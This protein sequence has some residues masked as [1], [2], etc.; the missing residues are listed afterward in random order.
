MTAENKV[1]KSEHRGGVVETREEI[2][3]FLE[4]FHSRCALRK[5][6]MKGCFFSLLE[7]ERGKEQREK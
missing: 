7:G 1:G 4:Y 2:K 3:H 6:F 5:K